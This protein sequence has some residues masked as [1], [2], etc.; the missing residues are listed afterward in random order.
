MTP[1]PRATAAPDLGSFTLSF[2]L[3]LEF[4]HHVAVFSL[5]GVLAAEFALIQ[6]GLSGG[7]L[8]AVGMLDGAY[9]AL[10]AVVVFAGVARVMWGEAGW[11]FYLLN[12][13]FWAK[14]VLFVAVALLSIAPTVRILRW[15]R[16][17]GADP[18][19]AVPAAEVAELRRVFYAE[20][21]LFFFIPIFA[22]VMARGIGH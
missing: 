22:A 3:V 7:R 14:M 18:A 17:S 19:F 8:R 13:T 5:L 16:A 2:D 6:P 20:F 9:G 1:A 15:R 12:W 21:A 11:Q 4:L 10:A